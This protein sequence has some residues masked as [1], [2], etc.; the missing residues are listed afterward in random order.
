[1]SFLEEYYNNKDEDS[2]LLSLH[3]QVEYLTT[4]KYIHECIKNVINKI[5]LPI[6]SVYFLD[7]IFKKEL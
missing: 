3:G 1:M 7:K 2:R 5:K 4:M 6:K